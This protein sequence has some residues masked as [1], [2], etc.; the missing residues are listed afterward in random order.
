MAKARP[1]EDARALSPTP[2]G[3][4]VACFIDRISF[5]HR[6]LTLRAGRQATHKPA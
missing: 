6:F 3:I 1:A 5:P 2:K 4:I